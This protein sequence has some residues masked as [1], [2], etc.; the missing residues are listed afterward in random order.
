MLYQYIYKFKENNNRVSSFDLSN[1]NASIKD[2]N[3]SDLSIDDDTSNSITGDSADFNSEE[4]EASAVSP[5]VPMTN[6]R[7]VPTLRVTG[8]RSISDASQI[9]GD[10]KFLQ[11]TKNSVRKQ[12]SF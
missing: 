4:K 8:R 1:P 3:N 7:S 10:F 6:K 9:R 11:K 12:S 5:F 2:K